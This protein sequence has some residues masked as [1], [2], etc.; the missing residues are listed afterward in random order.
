MPAVTDTVWRRD[1]WPVSDDCGQAD[2]TA[3][4]TIWMV[5]AVSTGWLVGRGWSPR[6][7]EWEGEVKGGK[8]SEDKVGHLEKMVQGRF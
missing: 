1:P 5:S 2:A 3:T 4:A 8:E 7:E 6:R